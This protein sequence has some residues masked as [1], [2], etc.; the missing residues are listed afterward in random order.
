M[1]LFLDMNSY[2]AS[3]EQQVRPELRGQPVGVIPNDCDST[4][5]IA[6]S[7]EAKFHGIK[8]GTGVLDARARCPSIHIV[9]SRPDVY[10]EHHHKIVEALETV[11]PVCEVYSIDEMSFR[12][13]G[14]DKDPGV[15]RRLAMEMKTAIRARVGEWM[16]CS[17]GI[18]PNPMLAKAAGEMVKPDGMVLIEHREL[19]E[20]LYTLKVTD[21]PGINIGIERRLRSHGIYTMPQLCT[22]SKLALRAAWGSIVGETWWEWLHG[23][24]PWIKP[25]K[26]KNIGHQHVLAPDLRASESARAVAIR[27][28]MKAA[29]RMRAE[30]FW[31]TKLTVSIRPMDGE[32]W[33]VYQNLEPCQCTVRL[34]HHLDSLWARRSAAF[35]FCIG[36]TLGGLV[37]DGCV[38]EPLFENDRKMTA[39]GHTMDKINTKHGHAKIY[40]ASMHGAREAAPMRIPFSRVPDL[41]LPDFR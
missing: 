27:L 41:S 40:Y 38:E 10:I 29:T 20:R 16:R 35:V 34:L 24:D 13:R 19:P 8:T 2:F 9:L 26:R 21:L 33:T 32:S 15:A 37:R 25:T 3:V 36:V 30:G 5:V 7:Y 4:C 23:R 11:H 14:H 18:A 31:C 22:A 12:L 17:I 28:L 6:A 1:I 39:L